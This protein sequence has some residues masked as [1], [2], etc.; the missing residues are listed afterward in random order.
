MTPK[1]L[2]SL[3]HKIDSLDGEIMKLLDERTRLALAI[4]KM[5]RARGEEI[6]AP[7]RES[8]IYRKLSGLKETVMPV[9][10]LKTI[11]R[12]I[13]SATLSLEKP[14]AIAYLGPEATFTHLAAISKFGSN[15]RYHACVGITEIFSE[16]EKKRADHGVVP[17]ENS[18]EG[19]VN[20]TLDRFVDSELKI[21]SEI[22][23]EVSHHLLST[24]KSLKDIRRVYSNPQ[25]FGQCRQWLESRLP[26]AELIDT[27]STTAAA[28]QATREDGA[29]AIASGLAA[30]VYGLNVLADGIEDAAN[31]QT[32]FLVIGRQ[33]SKR[34]GH[35]KTSVMI[36]IKDRVGALYD[37]LGPVRRARINM[38]MIESRPSR[39]KAWDYYFFVDLEGHVDD[40]KVQRTLA[41]IER[42]VRFLKVLGSYPVHQS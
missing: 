23:F 36:S 37:I 14:L 29:A 35:D 6:Y 20:H 4:G 11:Y 3:R 32:R 7:D 31:N 39:K 15:V 10:S 12:E 26:R 1:D 27:A 30:K 18:S 42:K 8:E 5:K 9:E 41:S 33:F 16:V 28:Q 13:M 22:V 17:I 2:E 24:A 19:A 25:A 21:C 34:T 40:P 38:T